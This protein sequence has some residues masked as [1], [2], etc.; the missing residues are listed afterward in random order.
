MTPPADVAKHLVPL[1][2]EPWGRRLKR[3]RED[4]AGLRLEDAARK[5]AYFHP[6][7]DATLCRLEARAEVP[8]TR[9]QLAASY[10]ACLVYGVDPEDLDLNGDDVPP[11]TLKGVHDRSEMRV[12]QSRCIALVA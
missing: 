5:V 1:P 10:I 2:P 4:V 8:T 12:A 11:G 9:S 6:I 3:A 7:S